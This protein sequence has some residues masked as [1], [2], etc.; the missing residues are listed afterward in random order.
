MVRIT[1]S[2]NPNSSP[3]P[4]LFGGGRGRVTWLRVPPP[5]PF[6]PTFRPDL[7]WVEGKAGKDFLVRITYLPPQDR[8]LTSHTLPP[9]LLRTWSVMSHRKLVV[10]LYVSITDQIKGSMVEQQ[11]TYTDDIDVS[12]P[13]T[14]QGV[15]EE[16]EQVL[17]TTATLCKLNVVYRNIRKVFEQRKS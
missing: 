11:S 6:P 15:E 1:T 16:V 13:V 5:F 3:R 7:A 17:A 14:I 12:Q 2:F 9:V 4:D 8:T 10:K